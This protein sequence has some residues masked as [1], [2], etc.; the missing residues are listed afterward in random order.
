MK[1]IG[2]R[3]YSLHAG[4]IQNHSGSVAILFTRKML[5]Q[6]VYGCT[7]GAAESDSGLPLIQHPCMNQ[8]ERDKRFTVTVHK[9]CSGKEVDGLCERF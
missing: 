7:D 5:L 8:Q 3:I 1:S 6:V 4:N 2:N 9:S